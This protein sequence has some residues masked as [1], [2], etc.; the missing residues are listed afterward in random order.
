MKGKGQ[1]KI[2]MLFFL[3]LLVNVNDNFINTIDL[4]TGHW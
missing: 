3:V 4:I 2:F 1:I